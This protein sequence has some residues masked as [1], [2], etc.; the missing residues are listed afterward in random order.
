MIGTNGDILYG[1]LKSTLEC[2]ALDDGYDG[3][4]Y[5]ITFYTVE[6]GLQSQMIHAKARLFE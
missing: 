4:E 5:R 2:D 6:D 3:D 1:R